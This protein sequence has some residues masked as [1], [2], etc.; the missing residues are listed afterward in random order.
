MSLPVCCV[1]G[2]CAHHVR[3]IKLQLFDGKPTAA[4]P[5]TKT[6]FSSIVLNNDLWFL[7][8]LLVTQLLETTPIV[9]GLP[10]LCDVNSDINWRDLIM[11]SPGLSACLAAIH[12]CLQPTNKPSEAEATDAPTALLDDFGDPLPPRHIL[13]APLAFPPNIPCN[14]YKGLNYT[15]RHPWTILNTNDVDQPPN[16]LNP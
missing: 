5:I 1:C 14:K 4:E 2:H 6:H 8:D 10:W 9:L 7:V 15:A 3:P 16:P 12:L 11:K 13:D